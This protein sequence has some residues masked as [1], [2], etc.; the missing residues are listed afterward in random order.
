MVC[1]ESFAMF[2]IE[3]LVNNNVKFNV[4]AVVQAS[5]TVLF[6]F[7]SCNFSSVQRREH[8]TF[9]EVRRV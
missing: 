2:Q 7:H 1:G 3:M 4:S 8:K 9:F 6:L 5:I